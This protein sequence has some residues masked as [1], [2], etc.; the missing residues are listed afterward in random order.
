MNSPKRKF[1]KIIGWP[2]IAI[3]CLVLIAAVFWAVTYVIGLMSEDVVVEGTGQNEINFTVHYLDN[4]IFGENPVSA[5]LH[6]LRLFTDFIEIENSFFANFS[7][8]LDINYSY[9]SEKRFVITHLGGGGVN[10]VIFEE[11]TELSR[12]NGR[13]YGNTLNFG[14]HSEP[15]EPGGIYTIFPREYMETFL[16][17]LEYHEQHSDHESG[18]TPTFRGF[19]AELFIE[20]TYTVL[21]MP[22]GIHETVSRGYRIPIAQDVFVPE[23]F[24]THGFNAVANLVTETPNIELY[25]ILILAGVII[26]S[27]FGLFIGIKC[28]SSSENEY[29]KKAKVILKKYSSEI[30]VS[31]S[32]MNLSGYT[33][34]TVDEFD[35]ILKLSINLNKHIMCYHDTDKMELCT[36]V[37]G[38]AYYYCIHYHGQKN[39]IIFDAARLDQAT[40]AKLTAS[41]IKLIS[42]LLFA[43]TDTQGFGSY[44]DTKKKEKKR[45]HKSA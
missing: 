43:D 45:N 19:S 34:M 9:V 29:I 8:D 17:F 28:I 7:E 39:N 30:V 16:N 1:R 40:N 33:V 23:A 6:F 18:I 24:G 2:I 3:S 44:P 10:P 25:T 27:S 12:L 5:D 41:E 21:A 31:K 36:I 26:L 35:E 42:D 38:H 11:T 32:S 22:V 37:D 4:E 15:D 13:I 14:S 20:F